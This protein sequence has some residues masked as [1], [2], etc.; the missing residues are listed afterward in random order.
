MNGKARSVD[1]QVLRQAVEGQF[2][3]D[4]IMLFNYFFSRYAAISKER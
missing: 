1:V 2:V 4:D 3:E